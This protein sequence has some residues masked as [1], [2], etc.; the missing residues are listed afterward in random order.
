MNGNYFAESVMGGDHEIRFGVDYYNG[1]T[2]TQT[3]YPN[4]RVAA[5]YRGST[6]S[7]WL[8]PNPFYN[9]DFHRTSFYLSDTAT[10]G[11]LTI[12]LGVRYDKESGS[13][14]EQEQQAFTWYEPGS[15][16]HGEGLFPHVLGALTVQGGDSPQSYAVFSPRLSFTYDISGNGKNVVKLSVARYGGQSGNN[17][18]NRFWPYRE[19]DVAWFGDSNND[20]KLDF[21]FGLRSESYG[22]DR[23]DESDVGVGSQS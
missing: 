19:T 23:S 10:F 1:T 3:M 9:A 14:N 7:A 22:N 21:D 17:L 20:G 13:F 11:K 8:I 16:H 5:T 2:T 12:N 6:T 4:Q 18:T 15:P